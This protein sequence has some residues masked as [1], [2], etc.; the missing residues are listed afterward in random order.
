M[1][2]IKG[3]HLGLSSHPMI[4]HLSGWLDHLKSP[5]K[6]YYSDVNIPGIGG[7]SAAA[8]EN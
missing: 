6:L 4:M 1:E 5:K 8:V 3:Q 2:A 7:I